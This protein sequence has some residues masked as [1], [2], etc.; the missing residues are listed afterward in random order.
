M[1]HTE[2]PFEILKVFDSTLIAC[3]RTDIHG[4]RLFI[5]HV[6][7]DSTGF[8]KAEAKANAH[9]LAASPQMLELLEF[10]IQRDDIA[11]S[12]LGDEIRAIIARAKG[13]KYAI[14][15]ETSDSGT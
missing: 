3:N 11:G 15:G 9:L 4:N 8:N 5:A 2:G 12:D 10:V 1:K 6:V 7:D 14:P 13:E